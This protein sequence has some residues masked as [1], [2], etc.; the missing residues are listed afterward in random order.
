[1]NYQV[2][3]RALC[4]FTA[5]V[6]DLDLRF[7][8]SPT[9]QE[10][11]TGHAIVLARRGPGYCPELTLSGEYH[12]LLVRGRADGYDPDQNLLEEIKTH[13]GDISRIPE[14]HRL[15]HWAQ[16]KVYG[17]LLCA[18][19]ELP[20]INLAVVYFNVLTQHET[21]FHLTVSAEELQQ[22]FN[23]QCSRYIHWAEY[24]RAHRLRRDESLLRLK[25]PHA[26]FRNGQRQL[27]NT[28]YRAA[29]DGHCLM[30]QA[31]T[32]IGKTLGTLFPQL[33]A[34]PEQKLD[35]LFF[36]TA[37]TPGRRLALDALHTLRSQETAMPLRVLEHVA[38]DKACEHP[39]KAC[40]G[41]SCP[42]AKGFYDRLP[43]ARKAALDSQ[44]LNH[45]NV[46]KIALEHQVC[47]YYLS[48]ELC[49]W[50]DVVVCD[51]NY[52]FDM[53]GLLYGLTLL[54]EWRIT[55]LVDEAHN[56]IDRARGMYTAELNQQ[57]F[58][59]L[60]LIA[61]KVMKA[62]L[63]RISRHWRQLELEQQVAYQ[64][65]P[66][67]PDLFVMALQK[68]VS[69]LTDH[70]SEQPAGNATELLHFYLD[71][72]LFC[73]LAEAFGPH[74]LF[75]ISRDD[76]S[77]KSVSTLCIR[78]IVPAPFLAPRFED[79]HSCTLFSATLSP[80]NYYA[81][82]LGLPEKT[83]SIDVDSPFSAE[84]LQVQA[85]SNLSTR[86]AHRDYSLGPIAALIAR[87]YAEKPGNYLAF[88]SS[89]SYLQAAVDEL[90]QAHPHIPV[91]QQ[92]RKM[93]ES[94]RQAFLD[95]FTSH[96]RGVG[97][98][99]LG[100]AFGEGIDLPG[101]QLIGAFIATLG[102]PQTNPVNEQVKLRM[103]AMFGSNK[104]YGYTYL[105][106]GLQKVV[107]AAGRVI[108]TVQDQGVVYLIDDRFNQPAIRKL[109]PTWWKV[110]RCRLPL[111][112]P[113]GLKTNIGPND[114]N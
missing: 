1:M 33:K 100:G 57:R 13:R 24:E 104:G 101:D 27:A 99:V 20:E 47:P 36:V 71:A 23:L 34:F 11:M 48:Q 59:A 84:Q 92:S 37:K 78:N 52:Y 17:W 105:Y 85:V 79:A 6:G 32:G 4:E 95:R 72:M 65:Y 90:R 103:D 12:G 91:W 83:P 55:L 86:F 60:R 56:L 69:T 112:P 80:A 46:R 39:D 102:L 62:P 70:L 88:F 18:E 54:N 58:E 5:K 7:T 45:Q 98:A 93:D 49:R 109:L 87:Q 29:R 82:L 113:A 10:G 26:E 38:R 61:P 73:R 51:Y 68:A 40:H 63:E 21:A 15:L 110:D 53:G 108:R 107:Q 77:G 114:Y 50:A 74:S 66:T 97:F 28:V 35:R 76:S 41:D 96:S 111:D 89:Y 64:V 3:V 8:P 44:W 9:A 106:P 30:A 67:A 43:D 75:D 94:E 2:A 16:A 25:F 14:N 81:D 31:T 19:R 22:F 42:L